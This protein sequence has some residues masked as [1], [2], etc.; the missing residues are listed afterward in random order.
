M[1]NHKKRE[2][3]VRQDWKPNLLVRTIYNVWRVVYGALQVVLGAIATVGLICVVCGFVFV[4]VLG[5]Y[6]VED[7]M[8]KAEFN[9]ENYD[10]EKT[11]YIHYL[12]ED[13]NVQILQQLSTTTD[14]QWVKFEDIPEDWVCPVCGLGKDAFTVIG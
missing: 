1:E 14:R 13:G 7:V 5:D 12:D 9:L 2:R 11:S 4:S 3:K 10:L 6:L 8:A